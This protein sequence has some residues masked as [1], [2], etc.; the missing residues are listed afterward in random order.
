MH[1]WILNYN[2]KRH[3]NDFLKAISTRNNREIENTELV[4]KLKIMLSKDCPHFKRTIENFDKEY[5]R[6]R[7]LSRNEIEKANCFSIIENDKG[8]ELHGYDAYDSKEPPI[9]VSGFGR[10]NI[11]GSTYLYLSED[12]YTCCAETRPSRF[13]LMSV[14][15]FNI[16][17]PLK[18][19]DFSKNDSVKELMDKDDQ[20]NVG[21]LITLLMAEFSN[22]ASSEDNYIATQ[23][24]SDLIR[25]YGYDG[26]CYKSSLTGSK[27][28][29]IFNCSEENIKFVSSTIICNQGIKYDLYNINNGEIIATPNESGEMQLS[30]EDC[31]ELKD[32]IIN[33]KKSAYEKTKTI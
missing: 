9:G 31:S 4:K 28:Y 25:K 8:I 10:N 19:I 2:A 23:Y 24:V 12:I 30:N 21:L 22:P 20:L 7:L 16:V 26:I 13:A 6:S 1:I 11:S 29:T 5:Y 14:A 17:K 33:H 3:F 15:I 32:R 27:N 18:I